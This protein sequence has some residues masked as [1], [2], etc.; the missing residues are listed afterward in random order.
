M[1]AFSINLN[2]TI[3]FP[4]RGYFRVM[5][6]IGRKPDMYN[7][8]HLISSIVPHH[9]QPKLNSNMESIYS[10][11]GGRKMALNIGAEIKDNGKKGQF[12]VGQEKFY[13]GRKETP[14]QARERLER[15]RAERNRR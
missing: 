6:S 14:E 7:R 1:V 5:I 13:E 12:E 2:A 11:M 4:M 9:T 8:C 10:H 3:A 15:E